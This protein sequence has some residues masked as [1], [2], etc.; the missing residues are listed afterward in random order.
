MDAANIVVYGGQTKKEISRQSRATVDRVKSRIDEIIKVR[1][2]IDKRVPEIVHATQSVADLVTY[3]LM[4]NMLNIMDLP[5]TEMVDS[6]NFTDDGAVIQVE[7][8]N[9]R[10][11]VLKIQAGGVIGKIQTVLKERI[12]DEE[13]EDS[14]SPQ[15]VFSQEHEIRTADGTVKKSRTTRTVL[16]QAQEDVEIIEDY[17]EEADIDERSIQASAET[18]GSV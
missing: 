13:R 16:K 6:E 5:N 11:L 18:A 8:P 3:E 17:G 12:K 10:N 1:S 7:T 14:K 15:V 2:A 9:Y 4:T